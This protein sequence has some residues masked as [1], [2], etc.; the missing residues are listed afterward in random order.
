MP[1]A[2]SKKMTLPDL[3]TLAPTSPSAV[4]VSLALAL[5]PSGLAKE[6]MALTTHLP[7]TIETPP[8]LDKPMNA[9]PTTMTFPVPNLL[10]PLTG[11][12]TLTDMPLGTPSPAPSP[13]FSA[14]MSALPAPA[15]NSSFPT[16]HISTPPIQRI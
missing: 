2:M 1:L 14:N 6:D 12:S 9:P 10:F 13:S 11:T 15:P 5:N 4:S 7:E 8:S 16:P 3:T